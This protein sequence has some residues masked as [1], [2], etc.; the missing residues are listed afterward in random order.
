MGVAAVD[1]VA[2]NATAVDAVADV[3]GDAAVVAIV[4]PGSSAVVAVVAVVAVD[5]VAD[6][7]G[8]ESTMAGVFSK[9]YSKLSLFFTASCGCVM[10]SDFAASVP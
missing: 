3:G 9:K 2:T 7:S 1:V 5:V 10:A 8:A 6:V 4:V